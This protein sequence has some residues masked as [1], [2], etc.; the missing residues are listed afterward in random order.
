MRNVGHNEQLGIPTLGVVF[1][2]VAF[3]WRVMQLEI[4]NQAMYDDFFRDTFGLVFGWAIIVESVI[5][6]L[7]KFVVPN[8]RSPSTKIL[9]SRHCT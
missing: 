3:M 4:E 8:L 9:S 7:T 1:V 5:R 2:H 6:M